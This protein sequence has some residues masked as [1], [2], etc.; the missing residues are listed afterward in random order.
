V[1]LSLKAL[2]DIAPTTPPSLRL[3][4]NDHPFV[5]GYTVPEQRHNG[6]LPLL[7]AETHNRVVK[8]VAFKQFYD[9]I[10]TGVRDK[11]DWSSP[12]EQSAVDIE[13]NEAKTMFYKFHDAGA[14]DTTK[15]RAEREKLMQPL[16]PDLNNLV[17][18][19]MNRQLGDGV[20][21]KFS[22]LAQVSGDGA[23]TEQ[24]LDRLA[25]QFFDT[26][27]ANGKL[28]IHENADPQVARNH[29]KETVF[30]SR[31]AAQYADTSTWR[32]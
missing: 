7:P 23:P 14:F 21:E 1:E 6:K 27:L 19:Y 2:F 29:F 11:V 24:E 15:L 5:S 20:V 28:T 4:N 10:D 26:L 30:K 22:K 32:K 13:Y 18:R 16:F 17:N 9:E 8:R 12:T 3:R 31:D 25:D